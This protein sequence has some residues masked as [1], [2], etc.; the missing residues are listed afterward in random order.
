[1]YKRI[2]AALF[3]LFLCSTQAFSQDK[4]RQMFSQA[5]GVAFFGGV[6]QDSSLAGHYYGYGLTYSPRFNFAVFSPTS[7]LSLATHV[8]LGFS[9]ST[10]QDGEFV[11]NDGT[12]IQVGYM[13]DLPLLVEYNFGAAATRDAFKRWGFF[14]GAGYGWHF[15]QS[16]IETYDYNY[17]DYGYL[18]ENIQAHGPVFDAGFRFPAGPAS[19]GVR[20]QYQSISNPG[21]VARMDGIFS[22]GIE[23]NFGARTRPK[24]TRR[25]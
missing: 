1:M 12:D 14:V 4:G 23:Y 5:A 15:T 10:N 2:I 3:A 19:L 25:R 18:K 16:K 17:G 7:S 8:T 24:G 9:L 11:S 6:M 20:F 21:Y 22:C 13:A